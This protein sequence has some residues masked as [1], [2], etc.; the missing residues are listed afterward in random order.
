VPIERA[1]ADV[2]DRDPDLIS[3]L[4]GAG[5]GADALGGKGASLDRLVSMGFRVPPGFVLTT[6]AFRAQ[7]FDAVAIRD[8]VAS[9]ALAAPT[10]AALGDA[11]ERLVEATPSF[12][13]GEPRF[14]V[15]SSAVGE[16]GAGA[17]YAGLHETELG[18]APA[19]IPDAVRRCWASLW[20]PPA[21]AY[22]TRR[23]LPEDDL[24]MAVVVQALVP[25]DAAAV[26]F[27]RHPITGREDQLVITTVRGLGDAMV[28]GSVTPDTWVVDKASGTVVSFEPGEDPAGKSIDGEALA[29]LVSL[30]LE[31]EARFGAAVDVEAAM[32]GGAW[33]LLQAR[34]ITTGAPAPG[35]A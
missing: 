14:A 8:G 5:A 13:S 11:I 35:R 7:A 12:A 4:R 18:V 25:A 31:V 1:G 2:S 33:Y 16:D 22:R 19:Q 27:T 10:A 29:A 28:S 15:R 21:V 30:C 32:A 23:G 24:A 3:W 9:A 34:P 20:S 26:A 17:S 6:A